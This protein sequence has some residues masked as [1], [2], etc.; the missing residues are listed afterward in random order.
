[1]GGLAIALARYGMDNTDLLVGHITN[2]DLRDRRH[3]SLRRNSVGAGLVGAAI[4]LAGVAS[5]VAGI[6]LE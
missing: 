6:F 4:V 3:R 2:D 1:M 5:F